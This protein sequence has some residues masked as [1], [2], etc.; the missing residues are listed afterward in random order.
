[1]HAADGVAAAAAAATT[2][3]AAATTTA[4]TAAAAA[5]PFLHA[6]AP[7]LHVAPPLALAAQRTRACPTYNGCTLATQ[8]IQSLLFPTY[9]KETVSTLDTKPVYSRGVDGAPRQL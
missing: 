8:D 3:A 6:T 5:P 2:T 7:S 9:D 4:T 1:M